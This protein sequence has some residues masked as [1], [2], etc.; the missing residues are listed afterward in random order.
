MPLQLIHLIRPPRR[1]STNQTN[2]RL[3]YCTLASNIVLS[4]F[5]TTTCLPQT[6]SPQQKFGYIR[7]WDMLP[8][9]NGS[10]DVRKAN[11]PLSEGAL[12]SARAYQYT[13]YTE[14]PVGKYQLAVAKKGDSA[15]LKLFAVDVKPDSF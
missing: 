4:L 6:P 13:S 3:K 15:P 12:F 10:F 2:M 7:F 8:P 1:D 9:A 11:A 5:V 14:I